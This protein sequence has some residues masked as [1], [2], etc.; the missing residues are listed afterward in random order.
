MPKSIPKL[1]LSLMSICLAMSLAG[2]ATD[3]SNCIGWGKPVVEAGFQKRWTFLEK[4]SAA[5][6]IA[7]G[8][9]QRC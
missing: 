3:A 7:Y 1:K 2:C 8:V 5:G 9:E 6:N 4:Q